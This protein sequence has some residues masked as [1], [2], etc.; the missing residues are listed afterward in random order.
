MRSKLWL[1]VALAAFAGGCAE[2]NLYLPKPDTQSQKSISTTGGINVALFYDTAINPDCSPASLQPTYK[3]I[4]PPQHGKLELTQIKRKPNYPPPNPRAICND[5][6][7]PMISATY[8]ADHG[9]V[10]PD[11]FTYGVYL[12]DGSA[13]TRTFDVIVR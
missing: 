7:V 13:I 3:I 4:N 9:Y 5:R 11:N 2:T 8:T 6:P 12:P 10:G 1:A